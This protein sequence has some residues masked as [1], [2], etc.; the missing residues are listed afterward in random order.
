MIGTTV[1]AV[2]IIGVSAATYGYMTKYELKSNEVHVELGEALNMDAAA[3]ID[4][5]E[6]VLSD[7]QID[8]SN[9]DTD[10][11]G[12]YDATA[13]YKDKTLDF[14]VVIED[15]VKPAVKMKNDGQ[16]QAIAGQELL[17]SDMIEEMTDLSGIASISFG[18]SFVEHPEAEDLLQTLSLYYEA[19]GDYTNTITISDNNGNV[20]EQTVAIHVVEDYTTHVTGFHDWT[21]EAGAEIDFTSDLTTDDRVLSVEAKTDTVDMNTPGTYTLSYDIIGDDNVTTLQKTVAV[22]IVDASTSQQL[23]NENETVYVSG[24]R[25]KEK[26]TTVSSSSSSGSNT[27]SSGSSSSSSGS[28]SGNGESQDFLDTLTPGQSWDLGNPVDTGKIDGT[29][30]T[31]ET[32]IVPVD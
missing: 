20:Y 10:K 8:F 3:Y 9:V 5:R 17:A 30:N 28:G 11:V 14:T 2:L 23:A 25:A 29:G 4:A 1:A 26:Q 6:K 15:T 7:T 18:D 12:N 19:E 32:Y 27:S 13:T 21:I 24:N 31:Y 16:V 22:T